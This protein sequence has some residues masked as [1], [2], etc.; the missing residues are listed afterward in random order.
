MTGFLSRLV[1]NAHQLVE[2]GYYDPEPATRAGAA[3]IPLRE[4][5]ARA[6]RFPI[7]A[8][9]KPRSPSR[10]EG[11]SHQPLA[12]MTAYRRGGAAGLSILTEPEHFK[13]S[14]ENLELA[15][16]QR[17]PVIMK[18][19]VVSE[20]QVHA[21]AKRGASAVLVIQRIF[22]KRMTSTKRDQIV[23]EIHGLGMEALLEVASERE[24]SDARG[25]GADL[26]GINQR[27]LSTQRV[28][29]YRG[30]GLLPAA[31]RL[32]VPVLVMSGIHHRAQVEALRD[33]GAA[34]VLVG[35]ALS[36]APD[37]MAALQGLVVLR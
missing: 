23:A 20:R 16:A 18:D 3:A 17:L 21:A 35:E 30:I 6:N 31:R 4:S 37:P 34:G 32:G 33:A 27:D 19:I 8:E 10:G 28:N 25:S 12:L 36:M 24:L 13:G 1:D 11:S 5:L 26:I 9:V 7:I 2:Q 29:P 15:A 14:L 22:S